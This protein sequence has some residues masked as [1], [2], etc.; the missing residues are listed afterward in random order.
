MLYTTEISDGNETQKAKTGAFTL[1]RRKAREQL[2]PRA[3]L[4]SQADIL[5]QPQPGG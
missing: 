4:I 2:E 5:H 1:Y 3:I